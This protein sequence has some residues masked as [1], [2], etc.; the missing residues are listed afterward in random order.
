MS[1]QL[2]LRNGYV[3]SCL[4]AVFFFFFLG[5]QNQEVY[6]LPGRFRPDINTVWSARKSEFIK[7][8]QKRFKSKMVCAGFLY[9]KLTSPA[10]S[11]KCGDLDNLRTLTSLISCVVTLK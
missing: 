10:R 5:L 2:I 9:A 7:C 4:I 1:I 8:L 6:L 3:V 11:V